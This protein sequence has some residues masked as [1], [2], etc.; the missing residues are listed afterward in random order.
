MV[1]SI[2]QFRADY[3]E[4]F[5][6]Y[7]VEGGFKRLLDGGADFADTH[8]RHA[9]T[10]TAPGH[11]T[12]LSGVHANVHGII[13]NDWIDRTTWQTVESVE[14]PAFPLVGAAPRPGSPG[15]ILEAKSGRSPHYFLATTVG[16]QLK[17][18]FGANSCVFAASNKDRAAILLAGK[19]ADSVYWVDEGRFVTST[20][21][22]PKLPA[23]VEHF[24]SLRRWRRPSAARGRACWTPRPTTWCR[25]RMTP[26]AKRPTMAWA[27]RCRRNSTAATPR[28]PVTFTRRSTIRP[29]ALSCSASLPRRRCT[30]SSSAG[31]RRPTCSA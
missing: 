28:S 17:L 26:R 8:Y 6:P 7:F 14:D 18:R 29:T 3:L 16:D 30:R 19:L 11:A 10:K 13:A 22:R 27:A 25:G 5:R 15:G 2:D 1:I 23:W 31:T 4:R 20:Y 21:Y 12:I 9:V 24:N